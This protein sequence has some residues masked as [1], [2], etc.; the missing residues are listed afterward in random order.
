MPGKKVVGEPYHRYLP[1]RGV[2]FGAFERPALPKK[3]D[4]IDPS[5]RE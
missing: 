4:N 3:P 1:R 5:V 2:R